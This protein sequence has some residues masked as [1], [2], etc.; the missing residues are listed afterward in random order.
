M[1]DWNRWR[2]KDEVANQSLSFHINK[3]HGC[4]EEESDTFL[5]ITPLR[6]EV[7]WYIK[8]NHIINVCC[9]IIYTY[10]LFK[11]VVRELFPHNL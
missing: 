2:I 3:I 1:D 4:I 8:I 7:N 10:I 6:D 11:D 9:C 5:M